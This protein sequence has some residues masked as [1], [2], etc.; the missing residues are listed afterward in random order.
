MRLVRSIRAMQRFN[1]SEWAIHRQALVLFLILMAAASGALSFIQLGCAEDP[2]FT[3]KVALVNAEWPGATAKDM[4][5][6]VADP[7]ERK[8]EEIPNFD[9]VQ[10]YTRPSV[11]TMVVV[12]KDTTPPNEVAWL[13]H[14]LRQKL[15]DVRGD[16]PPA[17]I[18]PVVNDDYGDVD[19]VLYAISSSDAEYAQLKRVAEGVRQRLLRVPDVTKVHIYGAQ[20]ERIFVDFSLAKLANLGAPVQSILD[21][22]AK[23]NAVVPAGIVETSAQ[24]A[25]VRISGALTGVNTVEQTPVDIN[26]RVFRIGDVAE[27][28][29]GYKDPPD[30]L[31]RQRGKPSLVVGVVMA[32]SGNLL[33]LGGNLDA[34]IKEHLSSIPLGIDLEKIADQPKVVR[35]I[36]VEFVQS[37]LEAL[38]IVLLVG[39]L[40]LGWRTGVVVGCSVLLVLAIVSIAMYA[41]GFN[42]NRITVGALIISLGLLVDDAIIAVEM[43]V[44]KMEQG[45]PRLEAASFS[46]VSTAFPMLTGTLVTAAGFLPVGFAASSTG[47]YAGAIFWVVA[48]SLVASWFVAVIFTPYLGVRLLLDQGRFEGPHD[49][50]AIYQTRTYRKLRSL[51]GFCVDHRWLVVASTLA[52][53]VCAALSFAQ[54][55]QQFFPTSERPELFVEMRLPE[56]TGVNATLE[57]AKRCEQLLAADDDVAT[58]TTYVGQGTPR[59]WIG[60]IPPLRN[61]SFAE[62]VVVA[63]GLEARERLKQRIEVALARGALA[64]ARVRVDR[65]TFGPPVGFPVQFRVIGPDAARL[66]DIAYQVRSI[67]RANANVIDP[68]LDWDEQQLSVRLELDQDR[69]RALGIDP[70]SLSSTLQMLL[71]GV[72]ITSVREGIEKVAVVARAAATER[73]NLGHLGDLPIA[74]RNRTHVPLSQVVQIAY[75]HE[76]AIMWR[77]NSELAITVRSDVANGAQAPDVSRQIWQSLADLRSHL[78]QRYRIE[79]GGTIEES[80]RANASLY[81]V[82]PVMIALMLTIVMLQLQNFTRLSLVLVSAPLGIIGASIALNLSGAPFGFVALLGLIALSG[83][84]MRN[85]IILVDQVRQDLARGLG[86]RDAI[87]ESVVRRSRPVVLTALTAILA[88]IPL[89]RSAFWG[90]MAITIMGGLFAATFLTIFFLP[91]LYSLW[92]RRA[93]EREALYRTIHQAR[94]TPAFAHSAAE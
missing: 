12:F 33:A 48:I 13:F 68:S 14:L 63:K 43:M 85:S 10:T 20:E 2:Q 65:F 25:P 24:R 82:V 23:Q 41:A 49:P 67:M 59:F 71:S 44:V 90:P 15:A 57:T 34:A 58:W 93:L 4:Q 87:I 40:S 72:V 18:G 6:H 22:L 9:R 73:L 88:M 76:D 86:Y 27:V 83:M 89:S 8:L 79:M 16:L 55:R 47:E 42:L 51:V 31:I 38:I 81:A 30:F 11:T 56:G 17:V 52:V 69:A 92:F 7:I 74:A 35:S 91:A 32:K 19:S 28:S 62:V 66:R 39:F 80:E 1:L 54:V 3:F 5:D 46:W 37:F 70:S 61:E 36:V 29:H 78:D 26:G 77:R 94:G 60:L 75:E 53:F 45:L 64:E 50:D 84:D 21:S